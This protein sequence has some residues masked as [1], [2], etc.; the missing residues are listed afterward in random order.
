M[1][2][3]TVGLK[4]YLSVASATQVPVAL[5]AVT[6][7]K[8]A[9]ATAAA[10]G[11]LANGQIV[12][13]TG[14]GLPSLDDKWF[15]VANLGG[16][17]SGAAITSAIAGTATASATVTVGG[18][19]ASGGGSITLTVEAGGT[20]DAIVGIPVVTINGGETAAQVATKIA[21]AL[22]GKQDAGATLT[23]A[24]VA[25]GAVVTVTEAGGGD[26]ATLTAPVT[27]TTVAPGQFEL[28]CSDASMEAA[29]A[30][31]GT[32]TPFVKGT[33][34]VGFCI[35]DLSRDVP[36]GETIDLG[37]FCDP[38]PAPG[39]SSA[40]TLSW[41][42]PIDFCD[43]GFQE[44]QKAVADGVERVFVVEFPQKIGYMFVPV[45]INSYSEAFAFRGAATWTGG[46]IVNTAPQYRVCKT[47]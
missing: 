36:A 27:G 3:S 1:K 2:F 13:I 18:G 10:V 11:T 20:P 21:A 25:A 34:L 45:T 8:P 26:I 23:L 43:P 5:T 16:F 15:A 38:T 28:E 14:T 19:P 24:A 42:G 4:T 9:L 33:D 41:G 44:M 17:P 29:P 31:T 39:D 35:N 37:T 47:C 22:N 6:N 7:T 40:G 46:A 12:K 32:A 30:A